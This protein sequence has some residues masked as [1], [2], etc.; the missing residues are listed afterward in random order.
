MVLWTN[1][2]GGFFVGIV[3]IGLYAAGQ[4]A[5]ALVS[6]DADERAKAL[7]R[8][9]VYAVGAAGCAA[10]TLV[11]P[12][13]WRLHAHIIEYLRNPSLFN[14]IDEFLPL[15]F[16]H[17][18]SIYFELML[19]AGGAAVLWS[20]YRSAS[21]RHFWWPRGLILRYFP[22]AISPFLQLSPRR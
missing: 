4:V 16:R 20:L 13:G 12:Y 7:R 14:Q 9:G 11:N 21:R 15:N 8:A 2:H 18:A 5:T 1:L 17:P 3:L 10:A 19:L 22:V 6:P